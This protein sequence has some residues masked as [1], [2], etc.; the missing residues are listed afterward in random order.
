MAKEENGNGDHDHHGSIEK[1]RSGILRK[2][3]H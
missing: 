2:I 1:E 3:C